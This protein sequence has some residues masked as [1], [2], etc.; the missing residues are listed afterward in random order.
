MKTE[1]IKNLFNQ[2]ET[3]AAE[4][5]GIECWSALELQK[6]LGYSKWRQPKGR[7]SFCS[8]LF[9]RSTPVVNLQTL[10]S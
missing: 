1:E 3:A 10:K 9:C 8:K 7:N 4:L 5:E 6:L 2:F